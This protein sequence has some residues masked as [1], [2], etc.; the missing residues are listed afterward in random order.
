MNMRLIKSLLLFFLP[1][2]CYSQSLQGDTQVRVN[3]R[4]ALYESVLAECHGDSVLAD[5]ISIPIPVKSPYLSRERVSVERIYN[6]INP[7]FL[8]LIVAALCC[9]LSFWG[10]KRM[11]YGSLW[12]LLIAETGNFVFYWILSGGL[13]LRTATDTYSA[14]ALGLVLMMLVLYKHRSVNF[15]RIVTIL[16]GLLMLPSILWGSHPAL[17]AENPALSSVWLVIHVP[18]VIA[19]YSLFLISTI[20]AIVGN[21]GKKVFDCL[22]AGEI[23]LGAG[24]LCGSLWAFEAWGRYWGWDP[25]ETGALVTFMIYLIIL[26]LWRKSGT[27]PSLR[28]SMVIVGFAAVIFTWFFVTSGLHAY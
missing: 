7:G 21:I 20:A 5:S 10:K 26:F 16:T 11:L 12:L 18:L 14:V 25:K 4:V 3:G 8:C 1:F 22:L 23:T 28:R 15:I 2:V 9:F 24:V 13:P 17:R 6:R 19:S 27:Y